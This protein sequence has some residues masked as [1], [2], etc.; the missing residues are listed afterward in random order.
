MDPRGYTAAT[1]TSEINKTTQGGNFL[2][3][4]PPPAPKPNAPR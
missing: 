3:I 2:E 4:S 1:S